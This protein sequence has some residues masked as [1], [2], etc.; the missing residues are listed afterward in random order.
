MPAYAHA[1]EMHRGDVQVPDIVGPIV[2]LML[3]RERKS[4]L[5]LN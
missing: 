1:Y 2:V 5:G 4:S 3:R